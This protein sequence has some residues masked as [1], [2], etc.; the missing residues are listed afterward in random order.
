MD[1]WDKYEND[2]KL[3]DNYYD[4]I[5]SNNYVQ[6]LDKLYSFM[7]DISD[8]YYKRNRIIRQ[9]DFLK[10]ELLSVEK[11]IK[12]VKMFDVKVRYKDLDIHNKLEYIIFKTRKLILKSKHLYTLDDEID[13][14][15]LDSINLANYC[16]FC[17]HY[18]KNIC[19]ELNIE[20][21][22]LTI[23]PGYNE[24]A[25]LYG[26]NGYHFANVLKYNN[27][28]YLV[29]TTFSQFFYA[30]RN[31]LN[32][33]G[34]MGTGGC[35]PGIFMLMSSKGMNIASKLISD[36]Y[37]LLDEDVLKTYLDS[38]TLS[39]RNGLYYE[40]TN[41]FSFTTDYSINDYIRFL[42]GED[43]Q[44]NHEAREYLGY[45]NRPLKNKKLCFKKN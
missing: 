43:N 25:K 45:Q 31:N 23:H 13:G 21:Y 14:N 27:N 6:V 26:G 1:I 36:G 5:N 40:N 24:D 29:D 32:R 7:K 2:S 35:N 20:S 33:L 37:I 15:I 12:D 10:T 39:F 42:K 16:Y 41:D 11:K 30:N 44:L 4:D 8:D 3:I 18:I 38:F 28:H 17:S 9:Y 34:I 22:L 19:D